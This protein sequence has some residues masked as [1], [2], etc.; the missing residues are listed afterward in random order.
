MFGLP[1]TVEVRQPLPKKA[2]YSRLSLAAPV[3]DEFV[4]GIE[5]LCVVAVR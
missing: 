4:S 5:A 1:S 2:F 3:K